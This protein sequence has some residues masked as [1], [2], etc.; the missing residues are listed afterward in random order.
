M[1][2]NPASVYQ[3]NVPVEQVAVKV[4][5]EPEQILL[6]LAATAVGVAGVGITVTVTEEGTL[7][8]APVTQA[9]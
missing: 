2:V 4:V 8:H 7:L 5:L 6:G 9:A 1:P 3:V